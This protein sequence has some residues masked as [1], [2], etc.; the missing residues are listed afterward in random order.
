MVV[1]FTRIDISIMDK[2][3]KYNGVADFL[4]RM[5]LQGNNEPVDDTFQDEH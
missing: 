1:T 3:G 4:S 5:V 2:L